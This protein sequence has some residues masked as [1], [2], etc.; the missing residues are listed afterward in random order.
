M[1]SKG[2]HHARISLLREGR[3]L[4]LYLGYGVLLSIGP[5]CCIDTESE[6]QKDKAD[7][8]NDGS[9]QPEAIEAQ[10]PGFV[11]QG[12]Q[13]LCYAE[14]HDQHGGRHDRGNG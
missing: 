2:V 12:G 13:Q 11:S 9:P 5:I 7:T 6:E 3:Y 10:S 8:P 14:Q 4:Q 1:Q